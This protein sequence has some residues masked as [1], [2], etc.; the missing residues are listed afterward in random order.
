MRNQEIKH[1]IL[2]VLRKFGT[3][4]LPEQ[5]L[6]WEYLVQLTGVNRTTLWRDSDIREE[7]QGVKQLIASR[8]RKV[9]KKLDEVRILKARIIQLEDNLGEAQLRIVELQNLLAQH[10]IDPT[11]ALQKTKKKFRYE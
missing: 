6:S 2:E 4:E 8:G 10:G 5:E 11:L 3:G 9:L 7:Y 1:R